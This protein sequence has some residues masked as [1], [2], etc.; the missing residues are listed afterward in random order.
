MFD[1]IGIEMARTA[2]ACNNVASAWISREGVSQG[3][4]NNISQT[5][6][7]Q[8]SCK[9]TKLFTLLGLYQRIKHPHCFKYFS[10]S[11]CVVPHCGG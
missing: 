3:C 4:P 5:A 7:G 10:L 1:P 11:E 2:V 9:S 6:H 8:N